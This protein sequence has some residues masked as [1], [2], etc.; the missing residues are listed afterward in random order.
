MSKPTEMQTINHQFCNERFY[1]PYWQVKYLFLGTF[2]PSGGEKVNCYY[3]RQK[4]QTWKLLS[5]IF[6]TEFRPQ[7]GDDFFNK[8]KKYEIGCI[9]LI[10][11]VTA[12]T[13]Y[14]SN[15]LGNG[16]SNNKIINT[17]VSRV[18]NT[19]TILKFI[20]NRYDTINIYST[21][22]GGSKLKE[23][24]SEI[25]KIKN[26]TTLVSPSLVAKV[27]VGENKYEYMLSNWKKKIKHFC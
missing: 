5:E 9:D 18:Y 4:N 11:S 22:G 3:G 24:K 16:Y 6:C 1:L 15:I 12:P 27:P 21:W 13:H 20:D 19:S 7:N 25:S 2:N 14:S 10:H 8:L 23:W 17:T 26:I